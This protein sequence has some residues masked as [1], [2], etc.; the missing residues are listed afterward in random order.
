MIKYFALMCFTLSGNCYEL[1]KTFPTMEACKQTVLKSIEQIDPNL[2]TVPF[3]VLCVGKKAE[4][5]EV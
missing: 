4:G 5:R 3:R 1:N 2:K